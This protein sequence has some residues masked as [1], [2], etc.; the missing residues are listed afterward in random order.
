MPNRNPNPN[1]NP[2]LDK[3]SSQMLY[4]YILIWKDTG[5]RSSLQRMLTPALILTQRPQIRFLSSPGEV[6]QVRVLTVRGLLSG[7]AEWG[8]YELLLV[9]VLQN[10]IGWLRPCSFPR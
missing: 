7:G 9:P 8:C 3:M 1:H 5:G 4:R 6:T 10:L 2:S